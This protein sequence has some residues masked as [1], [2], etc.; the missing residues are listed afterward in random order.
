MADMTRFEKPVTVLVGLGFSRKI[1]SALEAYVLLRDWPSLGADRTVALKACRAALMGDV[2]PETARAALVAFADR[3]RI[4]VA[5]TKILHRQ[6]AAVADVSRG[7]HHAELESGRS[8][9]S[10]HH[11]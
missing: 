2:D 11:L 4:L 5:E 8:R 10:R 3:H 6:V 1:E 7:R 9:P